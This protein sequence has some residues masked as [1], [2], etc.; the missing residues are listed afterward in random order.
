MV[1]VQGF[2]FVQPSCW[3][4]GSDGQEKVSDAQVK[5]EPPQKVKQ[6]QTKQRKKDKTE[7]WRTKDKEN[8]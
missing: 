3:K 1:C 4:P 5:Q 6:K 8:P 2:I 7:K